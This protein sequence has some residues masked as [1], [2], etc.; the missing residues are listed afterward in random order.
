[1][2][3]YKQSNLYNEI[4]HVCWL[5]QQSTAQCLENNKKQCKKKHTQAIITLQKIIHNSK[6]VFVIYSGFDLR[7]CVYLAL[8]KFF[9]TFSCYACKY[10]E[11]MALELF[12]KSL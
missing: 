10:G 1:M 4:V 9:S 8:F 12:F 2:N 6:S 11:K 5:E 7:I 3:K